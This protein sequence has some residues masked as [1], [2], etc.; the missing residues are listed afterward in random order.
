MLSNNDIYIRIPIFIITLFLHSCLDSNNTKIKSNKVD[1]SIVSHEDSFDVN[2][3]KS[4]DLD[5]D[6]LMEQFYQYSI[7]FYPTNHSPL[8][9]NISDEFRETFLLIEE[10]NINRLKDS[11]YVEGLEVVFL[12][13]YLHHLRC[14][15]Q[16]YDILIDSDSVSTKLGYDLK[17]YLGYKDIS[18][19]GFS[20]HMLYTWKYKKI[21]FENMD[22]SD[23]KWQIADSIR[24]KDQELM[25]MYKSMEIGN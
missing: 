20:S 5:A 8:S 10:L 4:R 23:V 15:R 21:G 9:H 6:S 24:R 25:E 3:K 16:S 22:E 12:K 14:C 13:L 7:D 17:E 11:L 2:L 19:E 1:L 18:T